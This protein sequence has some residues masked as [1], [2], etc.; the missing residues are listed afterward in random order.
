MNYS[1]SL[2]FTAG[3]S[4][5]SSTTSCTFYSSSIS[6]SESAFFPPINSYEDTLLDSVF[7]PYLEADFGQA[8]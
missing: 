4:I 3:N 8:D 5:S 2:K 6:S 7:L 1:T